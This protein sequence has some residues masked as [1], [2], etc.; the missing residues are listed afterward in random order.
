MLFVSLAA[1]VGI[2]ATINVPGD[3]NTIQGAI[4]M[5]NN[6]DVIEVSV[7][8]YLENIDFLGKA[9][10]INATYGPYRTFINGNQTGSGVTFANGEGPD[11]ILRGFRITNGTGT[12]GSF[13]SRGNSGGGIYCNGASPTLKDLV[14]DNNSAT[15]GGGIFCFNGSLDVEDLLIENN[16]AEAVGGGVFLYAGSGK[17]TRCTIQGNE[18]QSSDGGGIYAVQ[19]SLDVSYSSVFNNQSA[20]WGGGILSIF[21]QGASFV[22]C[23]IAANSTQTTGGGLGFFG[24]GSLSL[25]NVTVCDNTVTDGQG[26][27]FFLGD[28]DPA[29]MVN[30][31]FWN[32]T[33][34]S[35]STG[36]IDSS[37]LEMTYCNVEGGVSAIEVIS[38]TLDYG[39]G[40]I[41]L[42]PVFANPSV[43][44][45]HLLRQSGGVDRGNNNATNLP[46]TD[47]E[48]NDR[49]NDGFVDM[50]ADEL[51]FPYLYFTGVARAGYDLN[52]NIIAANNAPFVLL[53]LGGGL[54]PQPTPT[55]YGDWW[56][57]LPVKDIR[58]PPIGPD[59]FS[60][61]A[62]V[63]PNFPWP[64]GTKFYGQVFAGHDLTGPATIT[65]R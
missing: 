51:Y 9:I 13:F 44:D 47:M 18:A 40:N 57:V 42:Q 55:F 5:A 2:A 29:T 17:F 4:D 27:G 14:I 56:L 53:Y 30:M 48:G 25:I 62:G 20:I 65:M 59:G 32:N 34:T 38:G 37:N 41:V 16:T 12:P 35:G 3:S 24:G 31:I 7:G 61:L 8:G 52:I 45:Y 22:N 28:V 33:A 58:L 19:C 54:T 36:A 43:G 63:V 64:V 11:S 10:T 26:G 60:T 15:Q 50:G 1:Q 6:G 46:A 23:I 21:G 39:D 49:I